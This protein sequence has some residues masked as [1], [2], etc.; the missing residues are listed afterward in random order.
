MK[1][2]ALIVTILLAAASLLTH[3]ICGG[4]LGWQAY[5]TMNGGGAVVMEQP[6][7]PEIVEPV[8]VLVATPEPV[9]LPERVEMEKY[10][11]DS[12]DHAIIHAYRGGE[13]VWTRELTPQQST[14]LEAFSELGVVDGLYLYSDVGT[15]TALDLATGEL[16]WENSDFGGAAS[17]F[18]WDEQ[19]NLYL[20]G[21]YG[22]DFFMMNTAGQTIQRIDS[23]HEDYFWAIDIR[24]LPE[25]AVEVTMSMSAY[26]DEGLYPI[27][28]DLND[29]SCT[30]GEQVEQLET[31]KWIEAYAEEI[32]SEEEEY[33]GYALLTVGG[34]IPVLYRNGNYTAQGDTVSIYDP[35]LDMVHTYSIGIDSLQYVFM[36]NLLREEY[37]HMGDYGDTIFCVEDGD[38]V[39][40]AYGEYTE[41]QYS[42]D[43][44]WMDQPVSERE[45]EQKLR[46]AFP[47]EDASYAFDETMSREEM[48]SLLE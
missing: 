29:W 28:V 22:P 1:K 38:F 4:V 25:D 21:Y 36:E 20:S 33:A 14:E 39:V 47:I 48:L 7:K 17:G 9:A 15:V 19:G 30:V 8:D 23:L 34:D 13:E 27:R 26:T 43:Y 31:W 35:Y 11:D 41:G 32:R 2:T 10:Y 45:Y 12:M 16:V 5:R 6:D 18:D 44:K 3:T 37:G 42:T 24:K 40:I 46:A